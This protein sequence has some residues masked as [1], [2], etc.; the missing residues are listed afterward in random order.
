MATQYE[1]VIRFRN[2]Q[3]AEGRGSIL[4]RII[5]SASVAETTARKI[6]ADLG[7]SILFDG[8]TLCGF[9]YP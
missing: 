6:A 9:E 7:P 8:M 2:D 5:A 4:Y 1:F 3:E